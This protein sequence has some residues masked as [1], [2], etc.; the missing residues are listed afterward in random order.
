MIMMFLRLLRQEYSL[1]QKHCHRCI[2]GKTKDRDNRRA[3]DDGP[4]NV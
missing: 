2:I 1:S 3:I 4:V